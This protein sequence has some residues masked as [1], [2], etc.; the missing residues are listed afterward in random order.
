MEEFNKGDNQT[1]EMIDHNDLAI[2]KA[3]AANGRASYQEIANELNVS[4]VTVHERVKKL[5]NKGIISGIYAQINPEALGYTV[6][7]YVGLITSQGKQSY[8]VLDSLQGIEEIEEIHIITGK[9]DVL[10][11]IRAKNHRHLQE[12]LFEKV[13]AIYG[14]DRSE[15]MIILSSP[16]ENRGLNLSQ[17]QIE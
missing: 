3:L 9:Y 6:C 11:K 14:F 12:I 2:L 5:I 13:G 17:I 1:T 16:K 7:A 10:I 8:K 15:T 4:R